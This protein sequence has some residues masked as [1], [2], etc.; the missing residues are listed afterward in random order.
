MFRVGAIIT[1]VNVVR[2]GFWLVYFCF[3]VCVCVYFDIILIS[4]G[5]MKCGMSHQYTLM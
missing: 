5:E 3:F 4:L 2:Q 1:A